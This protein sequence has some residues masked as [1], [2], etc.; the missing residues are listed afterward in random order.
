[1]ATGSVWEMQVPNANYKVRIVAGNPVL[2]SGSE[3]EHITVEGQNLMN[4]AISTTTRFRDATNTF[5]VADGKLTVALGANAAGTRICFIEI[6]SYDVVSNIAPGLAI[7]SPGDGSQLYQPSSVSIAAIAAD[8]DT[9]I[10]L[11][12]FFVDGAKIG[13]DT[14]APYSAVWASPVYGTHLITAR[15]TDIAGGVGDSQPV[16]V[17]VNTANVAG[18]RGEYFDNVNL[19]NLAFIRADGS[20]NF[21]WGNGTPDPRIA[22]GSYS[23][24]WSGKISPRYSQTY[25]FTTTTDD[26]ARLW[27]NGQLLVDHWV[28]QGATPWTG[29]IALV[30]NQSYDIVME[31][32]QGGGDASA[33]LYWSSASQGQEIIPSSRTT[34][35]P[36]V[37]LLPTIVLTAPST[38]AA[39]FPIDP[40]S[41]AASATDP[42]GTMNRVEFWADGNLLGQDTTA[43]YTWNWTGGLKTGTH[44]VWAVAYDGAN[45]STASA[46]VNVE[47]LPFA[48]HPVS[49]QQ[50]ANP[51]RVAFTLG[52]TV[53]AGRG[54]TIE[55]SENLFNWA[56]LQSG[57]STGSPIEVTDTAVGARQRF[58]RM[59]ITN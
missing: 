5:T 4:A 16:G 42:D 24:R 21:D 40:I 50:L 9:P 33:K 35:P 47:S 8:A 17:T 37:N 15:A 39:V 46:A 23:V 57:I 12:E 52:T 45:A 1:M 26:G 32:Y 20:V 19:T 30:A 28:D 59:G 49:V 6:T 51:D 56:T 34:V 14:A 38:G 36:P 48:V 18:L 11:M 29:T 41:L 10:A 22:A 7:S 3:T 13:E 27:V 44:S 31:Y 54:Y 58:Y 43:P 53:P 2:A 25:T 55:W